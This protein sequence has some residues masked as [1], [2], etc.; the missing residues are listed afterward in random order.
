MN[1]KKEIIIDLNIVTI[2][3]WFTAF[4]I[5]S[6]SRNLTLGCSAEDDIIPTLGNLCS[7]MQSC[8]DL[9]F[10]KGPNKAPNLLNWN[11]GFKQFENLP[12][13]YS[14]TFDSWSP[15]TNLTICD[16]VFVNFNSHIINPDIKIF[17]LFEGVAA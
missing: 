1:K 3:E 11:T 16:K 15:T 17:K 14:S 8:F 13:H 9:L 4:G 10:S 12:D 2:A 5:F 6:S 7:I